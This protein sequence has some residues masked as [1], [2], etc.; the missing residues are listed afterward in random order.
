[1]ADAPFIAIVMAKQS[2]GGKEEKPPAAFPQT[3]V[4][5]V[6]RTQDWHDLVFAR[7]EIS[8]SYS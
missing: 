8:R 7:I 4:V 1:M 6:G 3:S 2:G 5:A